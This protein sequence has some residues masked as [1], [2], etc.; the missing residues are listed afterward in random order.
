MERQQP[1]NDAGQSTQVT[2]SISAG[3]I[4]TAGTATITV[5]N[6]S[7][8]GGVSNSLSF[9]I[10]GA[11]SPVPTIGSISPDSA[12]AGDVGFTMTVTG[13]NFVSGSTV[14]V[15]GLA[16]PTTFINATTL[17]AEIPATDIAAPGTRRVGVRT[18]PPGGGASGTLNLSVSSL[19]PS[20]DSLAPARVIAGGTGQTLTVIGKV[21]F[22]GASIR[23]N[24]SPRPTTRLNDYQV[25]TSLLPADIATPQVLT[26][27]VTNPGGA[28]SSPLP[29]SVLPRVTSVSAAS[30]SVGAQAADSILAAFST[31]LATGVVANNGTE[32]PTT[33]GGT[34]LVVTDSAGVSRDQSLFFVSPGQINYHLHAETAI[35]PA[36]VTVFLNNQVV[37][38]GE[39]TV[40]ALA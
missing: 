8:G 39:L 27:T 1:G 20:L 35:G 23:I 36:T 16:R 25:T 34:R 17:T 29:L 31:G 4:A 15:D 9:T 3:D 14:E 18:P 10:S 33:L 13:T 2:A 28:E 22:N 30:Y 32:L 38:L 6:P 7:P 19:P 26:I 40:G 24:S 5:I 11:A 21:F 12:F 37:A